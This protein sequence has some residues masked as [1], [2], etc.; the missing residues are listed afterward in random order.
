LFHANDAG[1]AL[2]EYLPGYREFSA[3]AQ[4]DPDDLSAK[5]EV[6]AMAYRMGYVTDRLADWLPVVGPAVRLSSRAYY[7]ECLAARRD[8]AKADPRDTRGRIDVMVVQGRLGNIAEVEKLAESLRKDAGT[9]RRVL[10]Q[11]ACGYAIASGG[12]GPAADRCRE[13]ALKMLGELVDRGWK[14]RVA[15]ETDPDLEAI[16]DDKRFADLVARVRK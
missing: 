3:H 12:T 4:A 5:R 10:F 7:E 14:D 15:L 1:R 16:R 6:S 11:T 2:T 13:N 8:L 9:D